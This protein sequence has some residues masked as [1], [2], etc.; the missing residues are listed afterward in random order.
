MFDTYFVL[1]FI[2]DFNYLFIIILF[3]K[4]DMIILSINLFFKVLFVFQII[5]YF[6]LWI[7]FIWY[8]ATNCVLLRLLVIDFFILFKFFILFIRC[9]LL[10]QICFILIKISLLHNWIINFYNILQIFNILDTLFVAVD[11]YVLWF[12]N[13]MTILFSL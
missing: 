12:F 7:L 10:H 2:F 1:W 5:L 9:Y 6:L 4:R 3:F 11:S 13:L 8:Y